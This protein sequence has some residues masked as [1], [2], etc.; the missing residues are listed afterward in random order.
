M[1]KLPPGDTWWKQPSP[2]A[3]PHALMASS[4]S[5]RAAKL[6]LRSAV[7][8]TQ[9]NSTLLITRYRRVSTH[10]GLPLFTS[11]RASVFSGFLAVWRRLNDGQRFL[12]DFFIQP[13]FT[14]VQVRDRGLIVASCPGVFSLGIRPRRIRWQW[15][16]PLIW[17]HAGA[18]AAP[19]AGARDHRACAH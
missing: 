9:P 4:L 6:G 2:Q 12:S 15:F 18:V 17:N 7:R 13:S 16:E 3:V 1:S 19:P 5:A 14:M 11:A 10:P 8:S